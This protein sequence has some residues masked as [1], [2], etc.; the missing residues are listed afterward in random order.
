MED[1]NCLKCR[2]LFTP[3]AKFNFLCK[4]CNNENTKVKYPFIMKKSDLFGGRVFRK[5]IGG[6]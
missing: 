6:H 5:S 1:R 2:K 3:I 4:F